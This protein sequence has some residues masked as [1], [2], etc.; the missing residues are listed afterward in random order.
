MVE[1]YYDVLGV[2]R[3]A[4]T[5]EVRSAYRER[6][7]ETHPDVNDAADAGRQTRRLIEARDVLTDPGER[8]RYDELGHE[9]Y[10][11]DG[12]GPTG[13]SGDGA[14]AD[15]G[16]GSDGRGRRGG[17]STGRHG[18]ST[19]RRGATTGRGGA[20][21]SAGAS[22]GGRA[23]AGAGRSSRRAGTV[24]GAATGT[25]VDW[26]EWGETDRADRQ[27]KNENDGSDEES[28][29]SWDS[30]RSYAVNDRDG[31]F[32]A[33][34]SLPESGTIVTLLAIF[35]L[36]PVLLWGAMTPTFPVAV[37]GLMILFAVLIV[38]FLQSVPTAAVSIFGFWSLTLP[39]GLVGLAGVDLV[40][41]A[42]L[43]VFV[44]VVL[45]LGF[46]ILVRSIVRF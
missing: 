17:A 25:D 41:L 24:S 3:D 43:A 13:P 38:A 7:K 37:N 32:L 16:T 44:G 8:E 23:R 31:G 34:G 33:T 20:T 1:T 35:L 29:R 46:S 45:P 11:E 28:W 5:D 10:L 40:S 39:V 15:S 27:T 30:D 21:A 9:R 14:G 2:S 42:G 19:G 6:L 18:A 26:T 36:Y 12:A 4:S 22:G